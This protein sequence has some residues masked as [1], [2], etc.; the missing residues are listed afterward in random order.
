MHKENPLYSLLFNVVLPVVI[1]NQLSSRMGEQGPTLALLL[2]LSLPVGYGLRSYVQEK[3]HN[4][5]SIFGVVNVLFTGG[6]ALLQVKGIWFAVK[7]AAFPLLIGAF[8]YATTFRTPFMK[9]LMLHAQI[10]D[11]RKINTA[12]QTNPTGASP[13]ETSLVPNTS[14][15]DHPRLNQ[16]FKSSTLL[17]AFS[18]LLSSVMNF[19]L[20][21]WVFQPIADTVTEV[22][23]MNILNEQVARMTWM[24]YV[25]IALPLSLFSIFVMWHLVRGLSRLTGLELTHLLQA[26]FQPP[27]SS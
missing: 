16:L 15:I 26:K 12:L 14:F 2:A 9:T 11:V 19:A 5:L 10:L 7:E 22:E 13:T 3:K 25:V 8:A 24:G 23:K 17:F 18:F 1:L 27:K 20:A 21:V 6:L 4:W